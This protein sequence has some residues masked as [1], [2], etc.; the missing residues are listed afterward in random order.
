MLG[1]RVPFI[2]YFPAIVV[3]AWAGGWVGGAIAILFSTLISAYFFFTP[4]HALAIKDTNPIVSISVFVIVGLF[5]SALGDAQRRRSLQLEESEARYRRLLE[6]ANEGVLTIDA[7]DRITYTNK[8]MSEMLGYAPEEL[9][10]HPA[11]ELVFPEDVAA[12]KS[13]S[14]QRRQGIQ[15][16]FEVRLRRKDGT[17]LWSV[18]NVTVI[19]EENTYAGTFS[20]FTDITERRQAEAKIAAAYQREARLNQIG[21]A[22]RST[23]DPD[24]I[25]RAGAHALGEA[26]GVDRV[27]YNAFDLPHDQSWVGEDFHRPDLPSL[28]GSYIQS[29]L[30]VDPTSFYPGG[31]TLVVS[32]TLSMHWSSPMHSLA[33]AMRIRSG[34]SVPLFDGAMLVGTLAVAMADVPREWTPEEIALVEN[35]AVQTPSGTGSQSHSA[36]RTSHRYHFTERPLA[37]HAGTGAWSYSRALYQTGSGRGG[38]RGRFFRCLPA[39]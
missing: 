3:S 25:Q 11:Y 6:T 32:D 38:D 13:R 22:I 19:H 33:Q 35:V 16:Q 2:T 23:T 15:E 34:I 10:G 21:E 4:T 18:V 36:T 39:G 27:Y 30:Q 37:D 9:R 26:L 1:L 14:L 20:L 17:E 28:S 7:S 29:E 31:K 24:E 8:R 5:V 12:A